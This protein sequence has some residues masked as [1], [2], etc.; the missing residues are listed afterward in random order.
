MSD[1]QTFG[2]RLRSERERRG[3]SIQTLAAATK[4]GGDLW[5]GLERNDFSRWPSGIFARAFVRDYARVIG[6]DPE[7]TVDEFC[8]LFPLGDRR[9][10]RLIKA[11]AAIIGHQPQG[12]GER[13]YLPAGEE[14]R[15]KHKPSQPDYLRLAPRAVAAFVDAAAVLL[16]GATSSLLLDTSFWESVGV[17]AILYHAVSSFAGASP[18]SRASAELQH[19]LPQLFSVPGRRRAHA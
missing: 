2:P 1:Q 6:L 10:D 13:G 19:R 3:I 9:A 11:Q 16:L 5:E 4:V 8:R 14:R 18:G 12:L 15:G 7:E 17:T